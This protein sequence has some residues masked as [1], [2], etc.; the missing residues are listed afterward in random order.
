MPQ[1]D[2][3]VR[4]YAKHNPS[5]SSEE[6]CFRTSLDPILHEAGTYLSSGAG[7]SSKFHSEEIPRQKGKD[8]LEESH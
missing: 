8:L 5:N 1:A 7:L 2:G 6:S 3:L 4:H